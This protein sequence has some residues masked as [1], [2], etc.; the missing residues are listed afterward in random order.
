MT[1]TLATPANLSLVEGATYQEE[2]DNGEKIVIEYNGN[3]ILLPTNQSEDE[4][5][6]NIVEY[7]DL[8]AFCAECLLIQ[9]ENGGMTAQDQFL[10]VKESL[11]RF[12]KE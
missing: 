1:Y 11:D 5:L 2:Y 3:L 7:T 8:W 10:F 9:D 4:I 6:K 12:H